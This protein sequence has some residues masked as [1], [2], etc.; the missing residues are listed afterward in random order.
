MVFS[1]RLQKLIITPDDPA[2]TPAQQAILT[3]GHLFAEQPKQPLEKIPY[4]F[5]YKFSCDDPDC[6][7]HQPSCTDWEMAESWRR[8]K[9]KY[10]NAWERKFRQ[11]YEKE[12]IQQLDTHF[13]VGTIHQHP[14][15]WII[16]GLFYPPQAAQ[17]H[18]EFFPSPPAR[19]RR[20]PD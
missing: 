9:V 6:N 10:G 11:K 16:V 18:L 4:K 3:Q 14:K 8:W 12:M 13:F 20:R 5:Q 2:W 19:F 15:E 1:G 7:G 17:A